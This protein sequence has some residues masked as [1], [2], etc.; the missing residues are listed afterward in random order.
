MSARIQLLDPRLANQIAAG[1]VIERPASVVKELLENS[2]DAGAKTI[3][4]QIEKGGSQLILI[5]D[6]G[7]GIHKDDLLLALSRHATSKVHT[8]QELEQISSFGFR[9]EALASIASVSRLTLTSHHQHENTAWQILAEGRDPQTQF[10]PVAHPKGTTVEVRD[11]F[12]NTPARRKFLRSEQT[13]FSH[14]EELVKRIALSAFDTTIILKHNQRVVFHVQAAPSQAARDQR[15]AKLCGE[16]FIEHAVVIETE[17]LDM[18][19]TGWVALPVFTRSQPDLQYCYV[20]GRMVKD[21]VINH[22]V[23]QAFHDVLYGHRHPA[24]ILFLT[25]DPTA[26][27]VNAHPA[28]HEV[29]FRESKYVHDFIA[30]GL[31]RVLAQLR[32]MVNSEANPDASSSTHAEASLFVPNPSSKAVAAVSNVSTGNIAITPKPTT[33]AV[34]YSKTQQQPIQLAV[35]EQLPIY[36]QLYKAPAVEQASEVA[37]ETK[38]QSSTAYPFGF[39]LAQLK[40]VYILAENNEGLIIVDMHAAHE[41]ILYEQLKTSYE[42]NN[43]ESQTLLLPLSLQLTSKEADYLETYHSIFVK[44]D[45]EIERLTETSCSV[46]KVP[47]LFKNNDVLQLIRDV[48]TDLMVEDH[49]VGLQNQLNEIFATMACKSALQA[50]R[51]MTIPEMNALLRQMERTERIAHCNHGRP[52]TRSF[53][54]AELDKMFLR[55]R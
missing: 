22:A 23:K 30:K 28:K 14:I 52:T 51:K 8:L 12:F 29:R 41:R 45:F 7:V 18:K 3:E 24:F 47:I 6:D 16:A 44:M 9:G 46:R 27:D 32:P 20:N 53:S 40:G 21:K 50:H 42:S 11:L 13:E 31:Q 5:R 48:L 19:L 10:T 43:L 2:L 38:T 1:E 37:V 15:V 26:V 17:S 34:E 33:V 4:I 55:G 35:K 49:S 25:I 54:M 36:Q 39:A